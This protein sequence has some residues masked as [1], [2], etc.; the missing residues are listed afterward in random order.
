MSWGRIKTILI[1]L[2]L[3]T[4]IFLASGI[5]IANRKEAVLSPEV[6]DAAV[7]L[8]EARGIS[9]D[10]AIIPS[11]ILSAPILQ[12]NNAVTDYAE[13]AKLLLGDG[14]TSADS[15]YSSDTG[16]LTFSGD[17]FVYESLIS[18][19]GSEAGTQIEVQRAVFSRLKLLGF[20]VS[21]A[22]ILSAS[23]KDGVYSLKIRD[24]FEKLPVFSS[25]LEIT[26]T[27]ND[28]ISIS[29][30]W[31]NRSDSGQYNSLK[32]AA[33]VLVDFSA[34]YAGATPARITEVASGYSVFESELYHKS[35]S[36]IPVSKITLDNG[37][38][39]LMDARAA[40]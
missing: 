24:Y 25:E 30:C 35:A 12:A 29:G 1:I 37:G 33:T 28:I 5:F 40:E 6:A 18:P 16:R 8:L 2:F 4:D 31:F 15:T 13:F 20:D 10:K 11:K 9:V 3:F 26:A 27:K 22:K 21:D 34:A 14:F 38:E 19:A 23:V 7:R 17:K 36:L 32:S 39:Y